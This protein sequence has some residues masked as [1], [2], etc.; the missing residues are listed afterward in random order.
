MSAPDAS[1]L[2]PPCPARL[3]GLIQ[4]RPRTRAPIRSEL[5]GERW[6]GTLWPER[7]RAG[8][9]PRGRAGDGHLR[10]SGGIGAGPWHGLCQRGCGVQARHGCVVVPD[11]PTRSSHIA[12]WYIWGMTTTC[13]CGCGQAITAAARTNRP[14]PVF[15]KGHN[16]RG[17][18]VQDVPCRVCGVI[19]S[20]RCTSRVFC[21]MACYNK[22]RSK[23]RRA[24]VGR[25][26]EVCGAAFEVH[27]YRGT[28]RFCSKAC[29]ARRA[30]MAVCDACGVTFA[31]KGRS[32][33]CSRACASLKVRGS[34]HGM[35]RGGNPAQKARTS[36]A[37][38]LTAWSL[39]VRKRDDYTCV[40]CGSSEHVHAHHVKPFA[41]YPELRLDVSNG[42]TLCEACHERQHGHPLRH[43]RLARERR[44]LNSCA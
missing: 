4:C 23:A 29:W 32:R 39:A 10:T 19:F 27:R 21:S 16:L 25:I 9:P 31:R 12:V 37:R 8:T 41:D 5:R 2:L 42:E 22:L 13:K 36:I 44:G 43:L 11:L 28:A 6:R 20:R 14:P 34:E 40:R 1:P 33:F 3:G 38:G 17:R 26:C 18:R 7:R 30:L 24:R 15:L 35:W